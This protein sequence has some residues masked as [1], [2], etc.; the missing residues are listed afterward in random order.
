MGAAKEEKY[1]SSRVLVKGVGQR[2]T[3][4]EER[5][6]PRDIGEQVRWG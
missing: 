2:I 5:G 3:L 4:S 1:R 6:T